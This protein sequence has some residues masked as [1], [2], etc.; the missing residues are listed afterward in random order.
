VL[1]LKRNCQSAQKLEPY[2]RKTKYS[3]CLR[4]A[5]YGIVP[6]Y[7]PTRRR[8][9]FLGPDRSTGITLSTAPCRYTTFVLW[10]FSMATFIVGIFV[11]IIVGAASAFAYILYL[12]DDGGRTGL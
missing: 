10:R 1:S 5:E 3:E 6:N 9:T 12:S 7:R 8:G 11:V 4:Q 2:S